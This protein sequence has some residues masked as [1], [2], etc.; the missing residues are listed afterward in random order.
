MRTVY[1]KGENGTHSVAVGMWSMWNCW[2]STSLWS[3]F[4]FTM[5]W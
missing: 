5:C 2:K 1:L 4:H 3:H